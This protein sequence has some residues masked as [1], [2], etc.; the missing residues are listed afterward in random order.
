MINLQRA[1]PFGR[2]F[3][4]RQTGL[5]GQVATTAGRPIANAQVA[6]SVNG[7]TTTTRANGLWFL[8]FPFDQPTVKQRH[9]DG[10]HTERRKC[11]H[12]RR[13]CGA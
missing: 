2:E 1:I 4:L 11:Q 13:S 6:T 8:Y 7:L 9:R 12:E 5:R 3:S 10:D